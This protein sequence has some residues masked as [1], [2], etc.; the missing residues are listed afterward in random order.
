MNKYILALLLAQTTVHAADLPLTWANN[1]DAAIL[2]ANGV[3][4][5]QADKA[6]APVVSQD[7]HARVLGG[8]MG[9]FLDDKSI[10]EIRKMS[11]APQTTKKNEVEK[12]SPESQPQ[13]KSTPPVEP[14]PTPTAPNA[15]ASAA[16]LDPFDVKASA[17]APTAG[18]RHSTAQ[19]AANDLLAN[20]AADTKP[21]TISG[22]RDSKNNEIVITDSK[23]PTR[24]IN[25][26]REMPSVR[27]ITMSPGN[28][29]YGGDDAEIVISP[30]FDIVVQMPES[31]DW[32]NPSSDMLTVQKVPN[33]PN[34]I[35]LKLKPIENPVPMSLQIVDNTQKI[36][37]FTVIGV[38][39]DLAM[40]YPKTIIVNKKVVK[41]T[42]L[43]A[44]N[45]GSIVSA[46]PLDYA[47]QM[48]VGDAPNTSEFKVE[49]MGSTYKHYEGYAT[50][51][52]NVSR[53]DGST[54]E[55]LTTSHIPNLKFTL[56]ANQQRVDGGGLKLQKDDE[57]PAGM[58]R[59]VEWTVDTMYLSKSATRKNG[60]ETYVVI[61]QVRASVLDLED[62]ESAF[63]T[64]ADSSG[65]TRF[66]FEPYKR[67]FRAPVKSIRSSSED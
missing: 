12:S 35:K 13:K 66:D 29:W 11:A 52:F 47:V 25:V 55:K 39:A 36:W 64:V 41:K 24:G 42:V 59:D 21:E 5:A 9:V 6:A 58:S 65:Y 46:L 17:P 20:I 10:N 16:A 57:G 4:E 40:E 37:T 49:L 56:W 48:V 45:P 1:I 44:T 3:N 31:I 63:I 19:A 22:S 33:N 67:D 28:K 27:H 8:D 26:R 23:N 38:R 30:I 62:W 14:D 51:I 7:G 54:F 2:K 18:A 60:R 53:R 32:F 61:C 15:S 43:G 34:M 50:Y